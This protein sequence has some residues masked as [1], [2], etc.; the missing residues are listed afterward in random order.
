[1]EKIVYFTNSSKQRLVGILNIPQNDATGEGIILFNSGLD[2]KVGQHRLY[3]GL[4]RFLE[5]KGYSV[6]RFDNYGIGDSDGFLTSGSFLEKFLLVQ[7][8]C[9]VDDTLAAIQFFME[10]CKPKRITL[11]G[12]CGGAISALYAAS[13]DNRVRDLIL[14]NPDVYLANKHTAGKIN[15]VVARSVLR[16]G[17]RKLY[18][19]QSWIKLFTLKMNVFDLFKFLFIY[20]KLKWNETKKTGTDQLTLNNS[21]GF[22]LNERFISSYQE[23]VKAGGRISFIISENDK[24]ATEFKCGFEQHYVHKSPESLVDT[25]YIENAN[26]EFYSIE[27]QTILKNTI[28]KLLGS[29][30]VLQE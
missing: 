27:S 4:A 9:F 2:D 13:I 30:E 26:H 20:V 3:V 5:S 28:Y 1:M 22:P 18:N 12:I 25:I 10:N 24:A 23:Y 11:A 16:L 14:I 7:M 17:F 8:G 21:L 19:L 6:L 15:P 29:N